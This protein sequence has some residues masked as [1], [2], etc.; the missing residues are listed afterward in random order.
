LFGDDL[1]KENFLGSCALSLL[2]ICNTDAP[3]LQKRCSKL[4]ELVEEKFGLST[5]DLALLGE[6]APEVVDL[7]GQDFILRE[8]CMGA[9]D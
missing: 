1:T 5:E 2:E 7:Q 6:D 4:R 3:K 9:M 8:D